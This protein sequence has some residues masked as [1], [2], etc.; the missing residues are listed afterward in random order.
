[1]AGPEVSTALNNR[2]PY[3]DTMLSSAFG[4]HNLSPIRSNLTQ[5]TVV[6][7]NKYHLNQRVWV[8]L[9]SDLCAAI[10]V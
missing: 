6:N 10:T 4:P 9:K 5:S 1:M 2:T 7:Y 8:A 3:L